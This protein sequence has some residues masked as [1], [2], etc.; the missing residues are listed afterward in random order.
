MA[1]GQVQ[2]NGP[3]RRQGGV[4][5]LLLLYLLLALTSLWNKSVTVD[6][7]AH[8]PAACAVLQHGTLDLYGKNPPLVRYLLGAPAVAAGAV[9]PVP[10]LPT[11]GA[12]WD[13]WTYG[14][15]FVAANA[16]PVGLG[17]YLTTAFLTLDLNAIVGGTMLV[18]ITYCLVNLL[19]DLMYAYLNP[20]ITLARGDG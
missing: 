13:P 6:E 10:R 2:K 18:A 17:R 5:A 3:L 12:G 8:L 14:D 20:K 7:Y 19:V 11:L 15:R 9:V 4:A 16:G 1:R